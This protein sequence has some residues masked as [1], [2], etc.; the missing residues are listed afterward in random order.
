M[1][2]KK[3]KKKVHI[4]LLLAFALLVILPHAQANAAMSFNWKENWFFVKSD[5]STDVKIKLNEGGW[6]YYGTQY[7]YQTTT[8]YFNWGPNF[9]GFNYQLNRLSDGFT[10]TNNYNGART[11]SWEY[12]IKPHVQTA[13]PNPDGSIN[14]RGE[15]WSASNWKNYSTYVVLP[16]KAHL[17]G[18]PTYFN[19]SGRYIS[20][21]TD[22]YYGS[23]RLIWTT[24]NFAGELN[25][26][27][28]FYLDTVAPNTNYGAF[29]N[30]NN[31]GWRNQTT[32]LN[33]W[34]TDSSNYWYD[35]AGVR[36]INY[37]FDG[38]PVQF[39]WGSSTD[40]WLN[41]GRHKIV[42]WAIDNDDNVEGQKTVF[43]DVD[44]KAPITEVLASGTTTDKTFEL[45]ATDPILS[46]G[47]LGSGLAKIEYKIDNGSWQIYSGPITLSGPEMKLYY[48]SVDKADNIEAVKE[49]S[50]NDPPVAGSTAYSTY[51]NT[52]VEIY[53]PAFDIDGNELSYYIVSGPSHGSLSPLFG[54]KVVS[55]PLTY[56]PNSEYTGD[57]KFVFKVDDGLSTSNNGLISIEIKVRNHP[58]TANP[59]IKEAMEDI[60]LKF[61]SSDLLA[62][63]TDIDGDNLTVTDV[64]YLST[65]HGKVILEGG[66]ITYY[67]DEN[68][69]GT[70]KFIYI[71]SDGLH[72]SS[73]DVTIKVKE[74][75]DPPLA[76]PDYKETD[77]DT[78][79]TFS[80]SELTLNDEDVDGDLLSV[81]EVIKTANTYGTVILG[82][83]GK[84]T[85]TPEANFFG[86][87][88]FKYTVNDGRGGTSEAYVVIK[89]RGV[90]DVPLARDDQKETNEDTPLIFPAFD[91]TVNDDDVDGDELVVSK[92]VYSDS[93][94]GLIS[95]NDDG[96]INYQPE[97]DYYGPVYF[98]YI[99][100][101][102]N[103]GTSEANV[104]VNVNPVN[105]PPVTFPQNIVT[106][107][108][109]PVTIYLKALDIDKDAINYLKV[110]DPTHGKLGPIVDGKVTYTPERNFFGEDA[111]TFKVNDGL[112]NSNVSTISI[113]VR[114][115]NDEPI[116]NSNLIDII[117]DEG[118]M[119]SNSGTFFDVENDSIALTASVGEIT[120]IDSE[121][122]WVWTFN[123]SDGPVQSQPVKITANDGTV[124]VNSTFNLIV[125]NVSP[126]VNQ[127]NAPIDPVAVNTEISLNAR[128]TDAGVLDTHTAI[129]DWGD[130]TSS[131]GI[132]Q[133]LYGFGTASSVHRYT[134]SGVY[135]VKLTVTDKDGGVGYFI[136]QYVVVYDPNSG[137]VTGGGTIYSKAGAYTAEP[138][139]E[140]K[141]SFGFVSRYQKGATIP[142]GNSEFQFHVASL[143]FKS[144]S[145][146]WLVVSGNKAQFKGTGIINGNGNFGFM[147]TAVD[148]NSDKFR[149]K[150][151]DKD[152]SD[153][154]IYDNQVGSEDVAD[155]T[156]VISG[157]SIIIHKN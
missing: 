17:I 41:E 78:I 96:T 12:G 100:D 8:N 77:E 91:L 90:N 102:G 118:E 157:G 128:F 54:D 79:L 135:T 35:S 137:F 69:N 46:D 146:E 88:E 65:T 84:I 13:W 115:K 148:D 112:L 75:N 122:K 155:P 31:L 98:S 57:D 37:T 147:I 23:P 71:I 45:K 113:T 27:G 67:P 4:I 44:I 43:V 142:S 145:Y 140:G 124:S 11:L 48:R 109:T 33:L 82:Q 76:K 51:E 114:S 106:D 139:L 10:Y 14:F 95:L 93:I 116:I 39:S 25:V 94:Q 92:I 7:W 18:Q 117:L 62:N 89:V 119:A 136:Y 97:K 20:Y 72:D 108:D 85:Y 131:E 156:T 42:Y 29:P 56:T 126:Q 149:I 50:L 61:P 38:G 129:W 26:Y 6:G 19:T 55:L 30:T 110:D 105:D 58:P 107:E 16:P 86:Y 133:E 1:N 66:Y 21:W 59:D 80:S 132:V 104:K 36:G 34:A 125:N 87:A 151:W 70:A 47:T 81:T 121:R 83:D 150:V 101:D 22:N 9:S 130:G 63:D 32:L 153:K 111:F 3:I 99:V 68:F 5:T 154:I 40:I 64:V 53:L 2:N 24:T 127:I 52:P 138:T 143:K 60:Q 134:T 103:G 74:V 28:K 144:T 15:S 141:A 152:A 120:K 49:L 123:A 73:S